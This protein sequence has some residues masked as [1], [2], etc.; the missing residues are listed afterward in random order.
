MECIYLLKRESNWIKRRVCLFA[1]RQKGYA[2]AISFESL[3]RFDATRHCKSKLTRELIPFG[4]DDIRAHIRSLPVRLPAFCLI[5]KMI[6]E[7]ALRHEKC[8]ALEGSLW[9]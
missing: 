4:A 9:K 6:K 2:Q 8:V 1:E 3:E 5:M 7:T